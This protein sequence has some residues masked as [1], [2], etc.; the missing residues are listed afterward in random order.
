MVDTP[1]QPPFDR[2]AGGGSLMQFSRTS[3]CV[4]INS[5][6]SSI[7]FLELGAGDLYLVA[8]TAN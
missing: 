4:G 7:L 3:I 6:A 2:L 5:R 1:K 8:H